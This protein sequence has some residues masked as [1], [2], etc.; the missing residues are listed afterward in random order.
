MIQRNFIAFAIFLAMIVGA[1]M[2]VAAHEAGK[3]YQV[4]FHV[5]E[6]DPKKMNLVLNNVKNVIAVMEQQK[7]DYEI[8]IT[9]YGPGL[10]MLRADKS[11][12]KDR[13]EQFTQIY[14][15]VTFS[16]CGNTIKAVTK[17]EGKAPPIIESERIKTVGSGV[18][19]LLDRQDQGWH[20]IRP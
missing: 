5:D 16:A 15:N 2:P 10:T 19:H 7:K 20:Y 12:V 1:V 9:T 8:D 14:P 3:K 18:I 13:V 11:P 6:G 17:K 4:I